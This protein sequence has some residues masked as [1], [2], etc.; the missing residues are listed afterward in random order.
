MG[1]KSWKQRNQ[2]QLAENR[3][4]EAALRLQGKTLRDIADELGLSHEMVRKDLAIVDQGL[5]ETAKADLELLKAQIAGKFR[6]A[7]VESFQAWKLSQEDA[8]TIV[9][10]TTTEGTETTITV[11]GQSG[12]QGHKRNYIAATIQ[13]AKLYGLY[14]PEVDGDLDLTEFEAELAE[15]LRAA[16]EAHGAAK[17]LPVQPGA[18]P[19][20]DPVDRE[21]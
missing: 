14:K 9:Q 10:K 21:D 1:R 3:R 7:Q 4:Q 6:M 15:Q 16:K 12:N 17:D 2:H 5:I 18:V 8:V 11:K 19:V 13:E 20:S